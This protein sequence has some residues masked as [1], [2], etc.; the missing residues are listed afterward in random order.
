[1]SGCCI[2]KRSRLG[3]CSHVYLFS[4]RFRNMCMPRTTFYFLDRLANLDWH[5]MEVGWHLYRDGWGWRMY[6][7]SV[8]WNQ[9]ICCKWNLSFFKAVPPN[10]L[11]FYLDS[12]LHTISS[13]FG[14]F[15]MFRKAIL[16]INLKIRFWN[17]K[18][19]FLRMQFSFIPTFF[20]LV[21]VI[22]LSS[23][24]H[25]KLSHDL[26][27]LVWFNIWIY[28]FTSGAIYLTLWKPNVLSK[29]LKG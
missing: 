1:M 4:A 28:K 20:S 8:P 11:H 15:C 19:I 2:H 3:P 14:Y 7:G 29:R 10:R 23:Y 9:K 16:Q 21:L 27:A 26:L 13:L 25:L 24:L 18:I 12:S 22:R 6:V 17:F 5:F